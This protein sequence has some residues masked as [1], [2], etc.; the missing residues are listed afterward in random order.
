MH[1]LTCTI[2]QSYHPNGIWPSRGPANRL[3][4]NKHEKMTHPCPALFPLQ[5]AQGMSRVIWDSKTCIHL[6]DFHPKQTKCNLP[7]QYQGCFSCPTLSKKYPVHPFF[8]SER[9]KDKEFQTLE[10]LVT[11]DR[12]ANLDNKVHVTQADSMCS[13]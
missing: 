5:C 1:L 2:V 12:G 11:T 10:S 7:L 6:K 4:T 8:L 13:S 9:E 3:V